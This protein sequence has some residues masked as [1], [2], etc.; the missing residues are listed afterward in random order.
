MDDSSPFKNELA[1]LL[2]HYFP[3]LRGKGRHLVS[4]EIQVGRSTAE[5]SELSIVKLDAPE[6]GPV[7]GRFHTDPANDGSY[8]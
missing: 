3:E 6:P 5:V 1:E 8:S 7:F 4:V 2:I